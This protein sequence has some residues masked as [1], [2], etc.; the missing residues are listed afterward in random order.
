MTTSVALLPFNIRRF[1]DFSFVSNDLGE[2]T[3]IDAADSR[4]LLAGEAPVDAGKVQELRE[5][6]F[7]AGGLSHDAYA[8]RYWSR[9]AFLDS[10][11]ILHGFVLTERCNLGCQ[12]CHS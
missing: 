7:L 11:P 4:R 9:R 6:G 12:Y 1:E 2:S 5:K 10:G 8:D 3:F